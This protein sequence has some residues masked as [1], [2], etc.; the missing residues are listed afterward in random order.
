MPKT[1]SLVDSRRG[2]AVFPKTFDE[3]WL[4]YQADTLKRRQC[5]YELL[6]ALNER[7]QQDGDGEAGGLRALMLVRLMV[8]ST[9]LGRADELP[10]LMDEMLAVGDPVLE[11]CDQIAADDALMARGDPPV[12]AVSMPMMKAMVLSGMDRLPESIEL[13]G[14]VYD[15]F[16]D[17]HDPL[18]AAIA[19]HAGVARDALLDPDGQ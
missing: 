19:N 5:V 17:S 7:L 12:S 18:H 3:I 6:K 1:K 11:A 8:I 15:E 14:Q 16:K 10:A 4:G 2:T 9:S 13:F